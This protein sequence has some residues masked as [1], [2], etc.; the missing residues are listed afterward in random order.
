MSGS[1]SSDVAGEEPPE[2]SGQDCLRIPLGKVEQE[3]LFQ[4]DSWV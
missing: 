1:V 3:D 2:V 4:F